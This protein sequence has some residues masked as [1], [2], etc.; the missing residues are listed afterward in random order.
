[1][2]KP[3][4]ISQLRKIVGKESVLTAKEDLITYSY[5]ATATWA[6]L[7]DA[8]VLPTTT[9]QVSQVLQLANEKMIPVTMS[10]SAQ[11]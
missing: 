4:V 1:M 8:V 9:E 5:D 11:T 6:H 2:L 3:D 7:P 10:R